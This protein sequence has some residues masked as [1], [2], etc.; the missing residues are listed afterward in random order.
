MLYLLRNLNAEMY[1]VEIKARPPLVHTHGD[2]PVREKGHTT[3]S[4]LD[5]FFQVKIY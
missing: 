3:F 1:K 2:S 5:C 4:S